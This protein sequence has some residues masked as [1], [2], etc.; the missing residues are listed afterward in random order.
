MRSSYRR[1]AG[2]RVPLNIAALV[3]G[4]FALGGLA[5]TQVGRDVPDGQSVGQ[6]PSISLAADADHGP[7]EFRPADSVG[8]Q[9][10]NCDAARAAGDAPIRRGQRGYGPHLDRD[11]DGV[12]CE[13]YRGR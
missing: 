2:V 12:G 5:L 9:Y 7:R 3:I 13:P 8:F 4:L 10:P 1:L 6:I 11:G